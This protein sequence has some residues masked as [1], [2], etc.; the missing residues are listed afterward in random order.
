MECV[1]YQMTVFARLFPVLRDLVCNPACSR[2][3]HH[4]PLQTNHMQQILKDTVGLG[5]F[6]WLAGYLAGMILYFTPLAPVL[7]LT[8]TIV[9]TPFTLVVTWWWFH[10]RKS[11]S[12]RY[13][14]GVGIMWMLIAV[15]LDYLFIVQLL[16]PAAYYAPHVLLYYLLMVLIPAGVGW[17]IG[18]ADPAAPA[19]KVREH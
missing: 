9:F 4:I 10:T 18:R 8:L 5:I 7:G 1:R 19:G 15:L 11:L 13:Y 6:F 16:K 2:N 14:A 12:L 17:F 3:P